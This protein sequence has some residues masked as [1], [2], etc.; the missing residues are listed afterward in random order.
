MAK[1]ANFRAFLGS[2]NELYEVVEV[3]YSFRL[4]CYSYSC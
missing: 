1:E 3:D 4:L 2:Q